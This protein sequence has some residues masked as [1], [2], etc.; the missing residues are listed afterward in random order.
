MFSGPE[1]LHEFSQLNVSHVVWIPDSDLGRW[2][3]DL[4]STDRLQLLRV[5]REGEAWPL[6]AGLILGGA[7]PIVVMQ[8]TGLFESGDALRNI[9]HDLKIPVFAIIGARNWLNLDSPDSARRFTMPILQAWNIEFVTIESNSQR[10]RLA[11]HY[12]R[13]RERQIPGMVLLAE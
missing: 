3:S 5:C 13:C 4:E 9:A 10:N 11:E 1:I 8:T 6:A 12:T 7:S 2:E